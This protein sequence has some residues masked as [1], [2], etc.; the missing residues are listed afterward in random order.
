MLWIYGG[1]F[2]GGVAS[3]YTANNIIAQSVQRVGF[4]NPVAL[5]LGLNVRSRGPL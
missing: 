1:G 2:A 3:V 5:L 4:S